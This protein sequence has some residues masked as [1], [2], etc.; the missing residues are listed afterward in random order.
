MSSARMLAP[1]NLCGAVRVASLMP[2]LAVH[3][4]AYAAGCCAAAACRGQGLQMA[5]SWKRRRHRT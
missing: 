3:L 4:V 5:G 1:R 2:C